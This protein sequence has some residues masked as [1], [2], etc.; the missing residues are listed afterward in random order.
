MSFKKGLL[1]SF[2]LGFIIRL[3]PEILSYPDPIG[4]DTIYYATKISK[5]IIWSDWS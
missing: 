4:F 2:I 3:I 1:L 5:G